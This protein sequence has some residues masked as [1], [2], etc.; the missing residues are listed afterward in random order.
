MRNI[1]ASFFLIKQ[2]INHHTISFGNDKLLFIHSIKINFLKL[3][4]DFNSY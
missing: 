3:E 2:I 4:T 1:K